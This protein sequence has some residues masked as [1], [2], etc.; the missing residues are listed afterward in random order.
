MH[1]PGRGS[2]RHMKGNQIAFTMY[3][4]P[5]KYWTLRAMSKRSGVSMQQLLREALDHVL[6]D[7]HR[8]G[9]GYR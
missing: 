8:E 2:A 3:L 4:P 5:G 1:V 6:V 7:A 9:R